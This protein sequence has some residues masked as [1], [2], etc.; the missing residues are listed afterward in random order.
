MIAPADLFAAADLSDAQLRR[1][2]KRNLRTLLDE[3]AKFVRADHRLNQLVYYQAVNAEAEGVHLATA[4]QVG[5]QGGNR[6]GKTGVMLAEAAIQMTGIVPLL[7]R[8]RY[9]AVKLRPPVRVRLVV[10]SL[11]TAWDINLKP[12]LQWWE[13]SGKLNEDGLPGDPRLGHWG[14][15]PR[16]LLISGSWDQSWSERHRMLTLA[17][18]SVLHVMSV[19]QSLSEFN[20]GAFHLILEDEIP[21]EDIHRANTL[22]TLDYGGQII[23]GGTAP[24]ERQLAVAAGWFFDQVLAPGL[25]GDPQGETFAIQLWTERNPT[26]SETE[27]ERVGRGLTPEEQRARFHGES[28]HLAGLVIRGFQDKPRCWCFRCAVPVWPVAERCPDCQSAGL[29]W[30]SNVWTEDDLAW[31]GPDAWPVIF[32]FDPHQA[33]PAACGWFKIDPN[34]AVWMVHEEEIEGN[35]ERVRDAVYAVERRHEFAPVWRK[36]DPKITQQSNRFA[37]EVDGQPFTIRRAFE[38]VGFWFD[39]AITAWDVGIDRIEAALYPNPLTRQPMLRIHESCRKTRFQITHYT[40]IPAPRRD[41]G[42]SLERASRKNSDFPA[43]LRYLMNDAPSWRGLQALRRGEPVRIGAQG[44]GR[45][46]QT[47]Y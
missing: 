24:D 44:V 11:T 9:P 46:P 36:G 7:L 28:I 37:Q 35:A 18:G 39:D 4:R 42:G 15:I 10:T 5:I 23:T 14:L 20:Q 30:F 41:G 12:K 19:D 32:Y 6:A 47:G 45:N 25:E 31:P 1:L 8:G 43:L 16:R 22:R 34:D 26:L 40:L 13:W 33:R 38:D 3:A 29:E 21:P 17:N 27:I 2:P